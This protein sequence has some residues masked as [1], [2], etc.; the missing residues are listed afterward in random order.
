MS[1]E[2]IAKR[3]KRN[4]EFSRDDSAD[5]SHLPAFRSLWGAMAIFAEPRGGGFTAGAGSKLL[6]R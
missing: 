2:A 4:I 5:L 3:I 1:S 6:H